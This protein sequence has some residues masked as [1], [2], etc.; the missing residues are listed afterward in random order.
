MRHLEGRVNGRQ[1][2]VVA[3]NDTA[4]LQEA[5]WDGVEVRRG[6]RI[7]LVVR[8]VCPGS[9]YEDTALS[10]QLLLGAH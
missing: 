1:V 6:D 10:E 8:S 5:T 9:R 4:M 2:T 7:D 3:L